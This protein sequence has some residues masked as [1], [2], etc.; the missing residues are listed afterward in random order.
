MK[1][2]RARTRLADGRG[3]IFVVH[4]DGSAVPILD[5]S[6]CLNVCE[7]ADVMDVTRF[8]STECLKASSTI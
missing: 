6:G 1:S 5:A 2:I 4:H 7:A 8:H 3:S